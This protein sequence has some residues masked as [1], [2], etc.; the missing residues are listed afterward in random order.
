MGRR[1]GQH[2]LHDPRILDRIVEA[3]E[4]RPTDSVLEIGPGEGTLTRR[5]LGRVARVVALERDPALAAALA[6]SAEPGLTVAAVDALECAWDEVITAHGGS[7]SFKVVGNI[8]YY[9]TSPLIDRALRYP[10]VALIVFL[11]QRE[12][13]DRLAAEP[14]SKAYGALSVGVQA[15]AEVERLFTVR[16]GSFRPPPQVES[17]VV[18]MR[19]RTLP[20]V[21]EGRRAAFREFV[22]ALFGQRR[23]QL[24][25]SVRTIVELD[26]ESTGQVLR[27]TGLDPTR[28]VET[29]TPQQ[30]A[31]LFRAVVR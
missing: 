22:I 3:L 16:A 7:G 29:L 28:R 24:G 31:Q 8:P 1:L 10:Q 27:A 13:A 30:L 6:E 26:A 25:R 9:I 11:V 21:G 5:L 18:R 20:L 23:K 17:A 19:R 15:Y 14:G 12:V 2:F 4:P